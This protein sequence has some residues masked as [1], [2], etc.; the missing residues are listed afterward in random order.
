M[1]KSGDA[2]IGAEDIPSPSLNESSW[3]TT[4][5]RSDVDGDRTLK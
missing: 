2:L 3:M 4:W 5:F 1:A